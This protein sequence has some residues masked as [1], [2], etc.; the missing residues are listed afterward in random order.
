MVVSFSHL[1]RY[2]IKHYKLSTI[3]K[4][5][6]TKSRF[7]ITGPCDLWPCGEKLVVS[8]RNVFH[9]QSKHT[10]VLPHVPSYAPSNIYAIVLRR[11]RTYHTCIPSCYVFLHVL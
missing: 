8:I 5:S 4:Q 1:V 2:A 3:D 11:T 6:K 10:V 9:T 7:R